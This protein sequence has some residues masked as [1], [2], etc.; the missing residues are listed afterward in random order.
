MF[1]WSEIEETSREQPAYQPVQ[2]VRPQYNMDNKY[3]EWN[4]GKEQKAV[5]LLSKEGHVVVSPTK[6]GYIIMTTDAVG[7]RRKFSA[8]QRALNKPGVVLCTSLEQLRELA[9]TNEEIDALYQRAWQND[10]LLGCILP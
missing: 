4:G 2:R 6:V 5:D 7:L 3:I 9:N 1:V 8:K 10:V